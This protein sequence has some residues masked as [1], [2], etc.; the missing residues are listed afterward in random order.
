MMPRLLFCLVLLGSALVARASPLFEGSNP[1]LWLVNPQTGQVTSFSAGDWLANYLGQGGPVYPVSSPYQALVNGLPNSSERMTSWQPS[2]SLIGLQAAEFNLGDGGGPARLRVLPA[3]G[4]FDGTVAVQMAVES[5][6]IATGNQLRWRINGAA[7]SVRTLTAADQQHV[8]NGQLVERFFLIRDNTYDID[9]ELR[10]SGNQLLAS[11]QRTLTLASTHPDGERRDTNGDGL[12]DLVALAAGLDPLNDDWLAPSAADGW[13]LFDLWLRDATEASPPLDSDNDGWSDIDELWR[14]T[15]AFDVDVVLPDVDPASAAGRQA[16]LRYKAF[17]AARRLYEVEYVPSGSPAQRPDELTAASLSGDAGWQADTLITQADLDLAGLSDSQIATLRLRAA[18]DAAMQAGGLP[19]MRLPAGDGA[20]LRGAHLTESE[21]GV[22]RTIQLAF[23]PRVADRTPLAFPPDAAGAWQTAEEWKA[24]FILWLRS[25]LVQS[26]V[27]T[28]SDEDSFPLLMLEHVLSMEARLR[29]APAPVRLGDPRMPQ[30]WL[31]EFDAELA[32]LD[33]T[34]RIEGVVEYLSQSD[35][36]P[37]ADI[38]FV[39]QTLGTVPPGQDTT[40]WLDRR[41]LQ[42]TVLD[43]A[44]CFISDSEFARLQ[45]DSQEWAAFIAE[46]PQY[47]TESQLLAWNTA[48][49]ARR[50]RLRLGLSADARTEIAADATLLDGSADS[51]GD[52]LANMDEIDSRPWRLHTLPWQAD[53]DGD[54]DIDSLDSCPR[55]PLDACLGTPRPPRVLLEETLTVTRPGGQQVLLIAL[56]LDRPANGPV[57]IE[58]QVLSGQGD[59]GAE[60]EHFEALSGTLYFTAGQQLMLVPVTLLGGAGEASFRLVLRDVQGADVLGPGYVI[61][62]TVPPGEDGPRAQVLAENVSVN[63]RQQAMLDAS[64]ST[65]PAGGTLSYAWTQLDGPAVALSNAGTAVAGFTAPVVLTETVLDFRVTVTNGGGQSDS[66]LVRVTVLPVDDA[67]VV[68]GTARFSVTRGDTLTIADSQLLAYVS[69]PD[70]QPLSVGAPQQPEGATLARDAGTLHVTP[71]VGDVRLSQNRSRDL[72]PFGEDGVVFL[73]MGVDFGDPFTVYTWLPGA[74]TEARYSTPAEVTITDLQGS[75]TQPL[76]YF[77]STTFPAEGPSETRLFMLREGQPVTSIVVPL[78]TSVSS[79]VVDQSSGNFYGC[80]YTDNLLI[81]EA[82]TRTLTQTSLFCDRYNSLRAQRTDSVCVL[83]A[84]NLYCSAGNADPTLALRWSA[85]ATM[86]LQGMW[87][88]G[89]D[90][91]VLGQALSGEYQL[92]RL[93]DNGSDTLLL[94]VPAGA[95][96]H[97]AYVDAQGMLLAVATQAGT[98]QLYRWQ[99]GASQAQAFGPPQLPSEIERYQ[100]PPIVRHNG[101][102][103]LHLDIA[104]ESADPELSDTVRFG[105]FRLAPDTGVLQQVATY[106]AGRYSAPGLMVSYR[107]DLLLTQ[108]VGAEGECALVAVQQDALSPY[109]DNVSCY[110]LLAL[111]QQLFFNR[112]PEGTFDSLYFRFDGVPVVGTRVF[113]VPVSDDTGNTV[114]LPV[115]LTIEEAP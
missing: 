107:N 47:Y 104:L 30:T 48:D 29:G 66:A 50:Y 59:T 111:E 9:V 64:P 51:D 75:A 45:A 96:A 52:A 2:V 112:T 13:T 67:P 93:A 10:D 18:A 1:N 23:L 16:I 8:V 91:L 15:P 37:Q 17:P 43:Q 63:E 106:L 83:S 7:W 110:G 76:A 90:V 58:Y 95:G 35:T 86:Q 73:D 53:T 97:T 77:D 22:T 114:Q 54:G 65:D 84:S 14:G 26:P 27:V 79:A 80:P 5:D 72:R 41:L 113:T 33:A 88:V 89:D 38:D 42:S 101:D 115:E 92:W 44:G 78:G 40:G 82:A 21:D 105:V 109:L 108:P 62:H 74:G 98:L 19:P 102:L 4:Q 46:C 85:P 103:Y 81:V 25:N 6:G 32:T 34:H 99:A 20:L 3:S 28:L 49:R 11:Q 71:F 70:G 60:G 87:G 61:V 12:P 24:A 57:T 36:L 94:T 56:T 55:D 69:E 39:V 31:R 100:I 68:T